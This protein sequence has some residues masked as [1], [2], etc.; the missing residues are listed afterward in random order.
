MRIFNIGIPC[1]CYKSGSVYTIRQKRVI[2]ALRTYRAAMLISSENSFDVCDCT[3]VDPS[4]ERTTLP[5]VGIFGYGACI[6]F[7]YVF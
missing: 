6:R 5:A 1:M 3:H 7:L 2:H 4:K